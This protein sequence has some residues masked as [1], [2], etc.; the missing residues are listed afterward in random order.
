MASNPL[1]E[2]LDL[3]QARCVITGGLRAGGDWSYSA[4]PDAPVKIDAVVSGSCWLIA[5]DRAPLRLG[6]GDAAVLSG[7]GNIVLCSDPALPA[8][9]VHKRLQKSGL[10]SELG[11]DEPDVVILGGHVDV[12]QASLEMFTAAFPALLHARAE[13]GAAGRMRRLLEQIV[14][15]DDSDRPGADFAIDQYAQLLLLEVLRASMGQ[16]GALPPGWLRLL[17]DARLRPAVALLH[18]DPGRA[19]Q[20]PE[21]AAAA[22]MSRSHFARLFQQVSGQPPL[23]YLSSWRIRLAQRALRTSDVP[24]SALAEQLGYASDSTFSHAFTREAGISPT[25][26]RQGQRRSLSA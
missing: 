19:W 5:D 21:L 10:F 11:S 1:A 22:N 25:R 2:Q 18:A 13:E 26:Y 17:M 9:G 15:E 6:P 24:V 20:L 4:H 3:V 23:A 12:D 16:S 14:E 8:T 7:V